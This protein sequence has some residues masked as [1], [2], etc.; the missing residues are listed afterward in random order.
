MKQILKLC[1]CLGILNGGVLMASENVSICR[2]NIDNAVKMTSDAQVLNSQCTDAVVKDL[3]SKKEFEVNELKDYGKHIDSELKKYAVSANAV[4]VNCG[5]ENMRKMELV[6][7]CRFLKTE[8]DALWGRI[9][10]LNK[11]EENFKKELNNPLTAFEK[12]GDPP[13]ASSAE[14]EALKGIKDFNKD[15]YKS[16]EE[17]RAK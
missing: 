7:K 9:D 6:M 14:F 1:V 12:V 13:C 16:W 11:W 15:L 10:R 3:L 8:R 17:C 2:K 4:I 5:V